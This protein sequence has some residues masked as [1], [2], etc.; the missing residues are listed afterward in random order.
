MNDTLICDRSRKS[1]GP[2]HRSTFA[3][4]GCVRA[5]R[6]MYNQ[7]FDVC[8]RSHYT[9]PLSRPKPC[10]NCREIFRVDS[11][12][13]LSLQACSQKSPLNA[14]CRR[15]SFKLMSTLRG[16]SEWISSER[17]STIPSPSVTVRYAAR[18]GE[19]SDRP[20]AYG[21]LSSSPRQPP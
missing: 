18:R 15:S 11:I 2:G 13:G 16:W 19:L 3:Q 12:L 8:C 10:H 4:D 7:S 17:H 14:C 6:P 5:G 20:T 1:S 21:I 9:T